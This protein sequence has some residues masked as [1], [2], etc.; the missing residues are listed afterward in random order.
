[1]DL[2]PEGRCPM[3]SCVSNML[4][5]QE[6][7]R[8]KTSAVPI[9]NAIQVSQYH[10]QSPSFVC[11]LFHSLEF[12]DCFPFFVQIKWH[13]FSSTPTTDN[14][15][16]DYAW[17]LLPLATCNTGKHCTTDLP[18]FSTLT[19]CYIIDHEDDDNYIAVVA[20]VATTH[21]HCCLSRLWFFILL[22]HTGSYVVHQNTWF[23]AI[24]GSTLKKRSIVLG[25]M[26]MFG[27]A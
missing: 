7:K 12:V 27:V 21:T 8:G 15:L 23:R 16:S 1:M 6:R 20:A 25:I 3:H 18:S 13:H 17:L 19:F 26:I 22:L 2:V 11:I 4:A 24:M 9:L 14:D 5:F 10:V